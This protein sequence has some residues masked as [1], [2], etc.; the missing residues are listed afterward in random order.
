MMEMVTA[1][2]TRLQSVRFPTVEGARCEPIHRFT[3]RPKGGV[4]LKLALAS[5]TG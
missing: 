2:A 5:T 4:V 3:R 1:L